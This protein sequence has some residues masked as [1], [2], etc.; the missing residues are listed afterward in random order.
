MNP[1]FYGKIDEYM[2]V[3]IDNILVYPTSRKDHEWDLWKVLDK[4]KQYKV[5]ANVKKHEFYFQGLRLLGHVLSGEGIW[6]DLKKIQIV[7][8]WVVLQTQKWIIFLGGLTDNYLK[9][10]KKILR[11]WPLFQTL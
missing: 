9:F 7:R 8:E 11:L 4:L 2:V 5:L 10:T 3:Y 6:S 1:V